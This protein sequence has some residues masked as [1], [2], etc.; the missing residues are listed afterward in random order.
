MIEI[1][2][3]SCGYDGI[4][5]V[6]NISMSIPYKEKLCIVGPNGCGKTTLLKAMI[7]LINHTGEMK[8]DEKSIREYTHKQ[9][10][11][12]IALLCQSS[13]VHFPY[14]VFDTVSLG[15]YAHIKSAFGKLDSNDI[16]I[17]KE[18]IQNVDLYD[19][20][21]TLISELSGGQ[22]QRVYLARTFAQDPN[23]ILLDEPTNHLDLRSQLELF[24]F[25]DLWVQKP[26][27]TVIGVLHDLNSVQNF[28]DKVLL[29]KEGK[30]LAMGE[31]RDVLSEENLMV[32]YRTN[33]KQYHL[34]S[35]EK[36]KETL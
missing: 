22:L 1:K 31:T 36:W 35:L 33:V 29:L 21:D 20:K 34:N 28:A 17:V 30:P 14:T 13:P 3:L 23:I 18:C 4:D 16:D 7:G 19:K 11:K 12:K 27:R 6:H 25:L 2:N 8:I 15:R 32:A 9:L 5:V 26:E 24:E 10:A